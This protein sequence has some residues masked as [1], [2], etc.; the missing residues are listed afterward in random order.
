MTI[1]GHCIIEHPVTRYLVLSFFFFGH[2]CSTWGGTRIT[3]SESHSANLNAHC[4]R[5]QLRV[6]VA[7][8]MRFCKIKP[9]YSNRMYSHW[10]K[11]EARKSRPR[12]KVSVRSIFVCT[13][14]DAT[15]CQSRLARHLFP[16]TKLSRRKLPWESTRGGPESY[17]FSGNLFI[18][19]TIKFF[20]PTSDLTRYVRYLRDV[21]RWRPIP[22]ICNINWLKRTSIRIEF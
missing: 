8:R 14:M 15:I 4:L 20:S 11:G 7:E 12:G 5:R 6:V 13:I 19:F 10:G 1:A 18:V 2:S 3:R 21:S 17:N 22:E 16:L 9:F